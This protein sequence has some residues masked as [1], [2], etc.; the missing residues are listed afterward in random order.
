VALP[1]HD[2]AKRIELL[3]DLDR[4]TEECA[5]EVRAQI[6]GPVLV[7]GHGTG[8]A[9][10]TAL[11]EELDRTG[12]DLVGIAAGGAFPVPRPP[13]RLPDLWGRALSTDKLITDRAYLKSLRDAGRLPAAADAGLE[14]FVLR[15]FRHE[16][17]QADDYYTRRCAEPRNKR[18]HVLNVIGADDPGTKSYQELYPNWNWIAADTEVAVIPGAG[19]HFPNQ[20]PGQLGAVLVDWSARRLAAPDRPSDGATSATPEGGRPGL[21]KYAQVFSGQVVS[22]TSN[23]LTDLRSRVQRN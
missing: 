10:A 4:L 14:M 5:A 11:A 7:Y 2:A 16:T 8:A 21:S 6:A 22:L 13:G 18:L 12:V 23:R 3:G 15:A 17:R 20:Q 19:H 1:G 9:L